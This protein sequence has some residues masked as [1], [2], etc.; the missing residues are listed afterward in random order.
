M[1]I[2]RL[3]FKVVIVI[4]RNNSN[5]NMKEKKKQEERG[6]QVVNAIITAGSE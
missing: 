6:A 3:L 4:N 1:D 2:L 5:I